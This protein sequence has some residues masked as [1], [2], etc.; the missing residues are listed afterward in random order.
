MLCAAD[1]PLSAEKQKRPESNKD[2]KEN[3]CRSAT[4]MKAE[5]CGELAI[6]SPLQALALPLL[7]EAKQGER[8]WSEFKFLQSAK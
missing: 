6:M 4:P 3:V 5:K 7:P 8:E 1:G 2:F